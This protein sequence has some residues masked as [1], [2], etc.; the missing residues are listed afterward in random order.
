VTIVA[1]VNDAGAGA[2]LTLVIPLALLLV[3]LLWWAL[4]VVRR[5]R[6]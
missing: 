2:E 6:P 5:Q 4:A 1:A 3:V